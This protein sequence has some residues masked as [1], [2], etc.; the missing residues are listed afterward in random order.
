ME[1]YHKGIISEKDTDGIPMARGDAKAIFATIE[2]IAKQEGFGKLFRNGVAEAAKKISKGA[3]ECAVVVHGQEMELSDA[4]AFKSRALAGA[5]T[6][7]GFS[8][9]W[10]EI[11]VFWNTSKEEME[12]LAEVRFGS[13]QAAVTNAYEKKGLT[14]WDQ[15]NR[16]TAGDLTGTC[17]WIIPWLVTYKL[18]IP[19]RLFSLATGRETGEEDLLWV[20]Q[21]VFTLD[22]AFRVMRGVRRDSLPKKLFE[23]AVPDGKYKGEKLEREKFEK[24]LDEYYGLR[25][26][27]KDGIPTEETFKKFGLSSDW[28]VFNGHLKKEG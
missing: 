12:K 17:R 1:L 8:H 10:T 6:D 9:G 23:S 24:M 28:E 11:D 18:E 15:E 7:G 25:G 26:W 3:E 20:A 21:R 5:V 22:R 4:R 16:S 19:A 13:R 2:K 14:V 27:D